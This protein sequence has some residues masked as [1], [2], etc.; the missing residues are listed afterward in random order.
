MK[1]FLKPFEVKN[2][3]ISSLL[4][5]IPNSGIGPKEHGVTRGAFGGY[6][7]SRRRCDMCNTNV[8]CTRGEACW[9]QG[10]WV[11][12]KAMVITEEANTERKLP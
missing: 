2:V 5:C 7:W 8:S 10:S 11:S 12:V 4:L 6:F 3:Y 1:F 9:C